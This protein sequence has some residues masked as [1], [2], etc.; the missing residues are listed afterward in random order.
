MYGGTTDR[1]VARTRA[2]FAATKCCTSGWSCW[3]S[4]R[5]RSSD[6]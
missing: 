4:P 2:T 5:R 1:H 3:R 6:W